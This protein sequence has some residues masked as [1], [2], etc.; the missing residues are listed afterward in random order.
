MWVCQFDAEPDVKF[1]ATSDLS[2]SHLAITC[3]RIEQ[4]LPG[5]SFGQGHFWYKVA[6]LIETFP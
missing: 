1:S 5:S 4:P 2:S 3:S 6:R